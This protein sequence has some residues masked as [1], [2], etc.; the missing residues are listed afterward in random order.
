[1]F[2]CGNDTHTG[3][4]AH[5]T[6]IIIVSSPA[7][8]ASPTVSVPADDSCATPEF[9]DSPVAARSETPKASKQHQLESQKAAAS[10]KQGAVSTPK[11]GAGKGLAST[12]KRSAEDGQK[13]AAQRRLSDDA[14]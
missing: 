12:P 13:V 7:S 14:G 10:P 1:M 4:S 2:A 11:A 9:V 8:A 6:Y 5:Y 3:T